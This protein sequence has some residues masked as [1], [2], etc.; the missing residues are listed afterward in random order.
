MKSIKSIVKKWLGI[1]SYLKIED[2]YESWD[3]F[4]RKG[5]GIGVNG[6]KYPPTFENWMEE[7]KRGTG[8][9]KTG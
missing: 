1:G 6:E 8:N 5:T 2:L 7:L 4:R 9:A 3:K